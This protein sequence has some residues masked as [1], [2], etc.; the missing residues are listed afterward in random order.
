MES[1]NEATWDRVARV[2]LGMVLLAL[3]VVGPKSWWGLVGLVPLA[4]GL[5]GF[6]PL[7]RLFGFST[8]NLGGPRP[9]PGA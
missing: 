4:T 3:I 1:I 7:Y 9:S 6:C 8:C 2:V 5:F